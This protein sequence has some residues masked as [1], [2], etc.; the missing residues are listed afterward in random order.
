MV[1]EIKD[2]QTYIVKSRTHEK[3]IAALEELKQL[4]NGWF[5]G[6]GVA[7]VGDA[8][9]YIAELLCGHM[10]CDIEQPYI[11]PTPEGAVRMEWDNKEK[12][13]VYLLEINTETYEGYFLSFGENKNGDDDKEYYFNVKNKEELM[14]CTSM[15]RGLN[16]LE[17]SSSE[18]HT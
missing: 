5:D 15:M 1:T 13:M 14:A 2:A 9:D 17:T 7:L 12:E 3:T 4:E 8:V 10:F 6:D 11:Y 18:F 16:V